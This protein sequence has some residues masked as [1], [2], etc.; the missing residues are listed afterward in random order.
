[1]HAAERPTGV[2]RGRAAGKPRRSGVDISVSG[3][4]GCTPI[5]GKQLKK[6]VIALAGEEQYLKDLELQSILETLRPG[7]D[8]VELDAG[9]VTVTAILD[10]LRTYP[11]FSSSRAVVVRNAQHIIEDKQE[12]LLEY[13]KNPVSFSSL[14]LDLDR[15]DGRSRL[16][17]ALDER[18]AQIRCERMREYQAPQWV[19]NRARERYGKKL[20]LQDAGFMV[21]MVGVNPGLLDSELSKLACACADSQFIDRSDV[22][23]VITRGRSRTVFRLIEEMEAKRKP[24]AL[25]L[26]HDIMSL[27]L[28]D[29]R[30]GEVEAEL[31]SVVPYL[32]HMLNWMLDRL[33]NANRFLREGMPEDE[34]CERMKIHPRFRDRFLSNLRKQWPASECRRCHRLLLLADRQVKSSG[35]N[36]RVLLESLVI[37][38]CAAVTV[39]GTG[40]R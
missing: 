23:R 36:V 4:V 12:E 28:Y 40:A 27:G 30:S 37:K 9:E 1:M 26:L 6:Q 32:M 19:V 15:L 39:R 3:I 34:V 21:E 20:N 35:D 25:K 24:E 2:S 11:L 31:A 8:V 38:M 16:A 5:M 10:E 33:W 13:M 18:G 7:T 29:E 17:K 14:I 22:E